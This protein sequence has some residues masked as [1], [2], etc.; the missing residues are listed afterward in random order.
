M[1]QKIHS[2]NPKNLF[3]AIFALYM[4]V[5]MHY[6]SSNMGG[7]GLY[8]PF[9]VIGWILISL[10]IGLGFW[11]IFSEGEIEL[12]YFFNYTFLGFTFLALPLI[13]PNNELA[14]WTYFRIFG[15]LGGLL[16][17]FS[18][19]QF[20]LS[21]HERYIILYIILCGVFIESLLGILQY[22]FFQPN[23]WMDYNVSENFPY[24]IFQQRNIMGS[25]M[26][27]GS[28]ISLYLI[29]KDPDCNHNKLKLWLLLVIP[30]F[31]AIIIMG[32]KSKTVYLGYGLFLFMISFSIN[33]KR[34]WIKTWIALSIMGFMIGLWSPKLFDREFSEKTLEYQISTIFS[35]KTR[36]ENTFQLWMQHPF[37]GIGYGNFKRKYREH[38]ANRFANEPGFTVR[39]SFCDHPHNEILF[40][41]VEGGIVPLIGLLLFAGAYLIMVFSIYWRNALAFMALVV[42]IFVHTQTE[43][44]FYISLV[45]WIIFLSLVYITDA[46]TGTSVQSNFRLHRLMIIPAILIPLFVTDYMN[47]TLQTAKVITQYE[48][49]GFSDYNLLLSAKNPDAWRLKY[50]NYKLKMLFDIGMET[51][52]I[53]TLQLFL[54]QSEEL[55]HYAPL[56]HIYQYMDKA[57]KT[58]GREDD[59]KN[60]IE[61]AKYLYA[62]LYDK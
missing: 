12:T 56:P 36:Y 21:K 14:S 47:K 38:H 13:Y 23:N 19:L 54:D 20:K 16:F 4:L 8:L 44:P 52:K 43:L 53:E 60:V 9:N 25:F 37:L 40:W 22:Y 39:E 24:G 32:V 10:I 35:R 42:P 59:A 31:S 28:A 45:H 33:L 6:Y 48:R 57:L 2:M 17:Y 49:T 61:R 46:D 34:K 26:A 55:L 58:M 51:K 3:K 7:H 29:Q 5:G 27:T 11:Q 15:L 62:D 50:E 18:L 1:V 41:A 30:L